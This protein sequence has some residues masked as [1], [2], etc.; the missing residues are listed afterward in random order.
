MEIHIRAANGT[1]SPLLTTAATAP[2]PIAHAVLNGR[3]LGLSGT[4]VSNECPHSHRVVAEGLTRAQ[5]G[6]VMPRSLHD[7]ALGAVA[8][9]WTSS[10]ETRRQ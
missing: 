1:S 8:S 5:R 2:N 6:Q 4:L 7:A 10:A 9:A 3:G